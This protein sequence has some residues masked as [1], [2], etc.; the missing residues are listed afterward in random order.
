MLQ[1]ET[2]VSIEPNE[3]DDADCDSSESLRQ[4]GAEDQDDSLNRTFV[5]DDVLGDETPV[6]ESASQN[7]SQTVEEDQDVLIVRVSE[8]IEDLKAVA[9]R[10]ETSSIE[11]NH[12]EQVEYFVSELQAVV[13][14]AG[15]MD[16]ATTVR[17]QVPLS[18]PEKFDEPLRLETEEIEEDMNYKGEDFFDS[19]SS[20]SD[21]SNQNLPG[22]FIVEPKDLHINKA[23]E[24]NEELASG[25]KKIRCHSW[26]IDSLQRTEPFPKTIISRTKNDLVRNKALKR[27]NASPLAK[28]SNRFS[29]KFTQPTTDLPKT[30][31]T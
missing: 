3:T 7:A 31:V 8:A 6:V 11:I 15:D 2:S 5:I 26:R 12:V 18:E 10:K 27:V 13:A 22:P 28:I 30:R 29:I 23:Q 20:D 1:L 21:H 4:Q 16:A 14:E 9:E 24:A 25:R 19:S 17:T